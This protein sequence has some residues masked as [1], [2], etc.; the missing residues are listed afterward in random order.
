MKSKEQK[1]RDDAWQQSLHRGMAV[2][3]MGFSIGCVSLLIAA[4]LK[5]YEIIDVVDILGVI[6]GCWISLSFFCGMMGICRQIYHDDG[7]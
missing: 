6:T 7:T 2:F 3:G 5:R 1:A 4:F